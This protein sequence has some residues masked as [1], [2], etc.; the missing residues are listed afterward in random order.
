MKHAIILGTRPEIIKLSPIIRELM[1]RNADFY[2]I[3]SNQHY[4]KEMDE[5]F[6]KELE[7][8]LPK[9]NLGVGSM[10]REPM[11]EKIKTGVLEILKTDKPDLVYVQGDTNTVLAGALAAKEMGVKIAHVEAG[12]RSYD[13][14]MPEE[15]NRIETDKISDYL[16]APTP[17]AAE[18][19]KKEGLGED[20]IFMV[21]NT[22]VDSVYQN[23][24]IAEKN[25]NV[26]DQF[27]LQDKNY[28]LLTLHRPSN[29]DEELPLK[30]ILSS[31]AQIYLLYRKPIFF[32]IHPRTRKQLELFKLTLPEGTIDNEPVGFLEMLQL[33]KHAQLIMTDSGG[34]QEEACILQVP[35]LT[36]RFNTERPETLEVGASIL[37]G[38][39][40]KKIIE[41]AK[42]MLENFKHCVNPFGDGTSAKQI[43]NITEK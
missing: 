20:K 7:L 19:L 35:S 2:I 26:L 30:Q 29:V 3:H 5:I 11:I 34:L 39:D 16:F 18:I 31:L 32:P 36:L 17:K 13:D 23:L 25:I 10:D 24:E 15:V 43:I 1:A 37:V 14:T 28:F 8:P 6:F 41:G 27:G 12:L 38:N 9:Y 22:I 40:Q 4:S 33:E 42:Q 21:G